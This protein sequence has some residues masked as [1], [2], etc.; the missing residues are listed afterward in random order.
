MQILL[1]NDDG[2]DA[3]GLQALWTSLEDLGAL[4]VVAPYR[5]Q[6]AASHGFTMHKPLRMSEPRPRW[7][8]VNG[9]PADC[10]YMGV[11]HVLDERPALVVS[12]INRGTNIGDDI[13]YS[14]TVAAAMEAALVGI[15]SI[16]VSLEVRSDDEAMHWETA[17]ALARRLA[18][19]VFDDP[20]PRHSFLNL[21][22]PNRA[23]HDLAGIKAT[24]MGRRL[25][26]PLV[27]EHLDP[28]QKPYF[29]I[30][31]AHQSFDPSEDTDGYWFERGYATV[32]P[33]RPNLTDHDSLRR[34]EGWP[35]DRAKGAT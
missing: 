15:P 20:L 2:V 14:G 1:S 7:F 16:A 29:W 35:L 4:T 12:G 6:S 9:T 17:G 8:A 3:P 24:A 13:H 25:Y 23:L 18:Q 26:H 28:R 10:V 33:L 31:G 19:L 32:T 22:V 5:E 21:N 30:G 34:I 11:H 27:S